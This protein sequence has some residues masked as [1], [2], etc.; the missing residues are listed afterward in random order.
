MPFVEGTV[1]SLHATM[2]CHILISILRTN[3]LFQISFDLLKSTTEYVKWYWCAQ[4]QDE[5]KGI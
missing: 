3:L 4:E 1:L 2:Y 5:I